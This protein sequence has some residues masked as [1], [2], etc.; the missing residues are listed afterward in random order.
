MTR[1]KYVVASVVVL[2][3]YHRLSDAEFIITSFHIHA[4]P[5]NGGPNSSEKKDRMRRPKGA[6]TS[7]TTNKIY[8]G[9][10]DVGEF[11][12]YCTYSDA[13]LCEDRVQYMM[14]KYKLSEAQA[15]NQTDMLDRCTTPPI[16]R[17]VYAEEDEPYMVLHVGPHKTGTTA[18]QAFIYDLIYAN[19]TIITRDNFRVPSYEELPGVFAKEGVGLNLPHCALEDYKKS[20]GQENIGMCYRMRKEFPKFTVD[21]WNKSQNVLIVAEDFDRKEIDFNRLRFFLRPYNKARIVTTYRRLHDWLPSWY[22]QIMDHYTLKYA[23][24]DEKYPSFVEW[25]GTNFD[26]FLLAHSIE[27]AKRF[28]KYD[29]VESVDILN[30]HDMSDLIE[31][32]FCDHLQ[33]ESTCQAL[34]DGAVPSKSNVGKDHDYERLVIKASL[35]GRLLH[36]AFKPIQIDR[37]T[38]RL[39]EKIEAKN[40]SLPLMCPP[41]D[42]IDK[43]LATEL[44]QERTYFPEW[45]KKQGGEEGVTESFRAAVKKKF[46]SFDDGR[47]FQFGIL[48]DI[49]KEINPNVQWD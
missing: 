12:R 7:N 43:I 49:F 28:D 11:C 4:Q 17:K 18:M 34:K 1:F 30:M 46:C 15:K 20:G 3:A 13:L 39:K 9:S 35:Q 8:T 32:F 29:F 24:G 37:T 48:D 40:M 22:N 25:L 14:K 26:E 23:A 21:A 16:H 19:D 31:H 41:K 27:V 38:R 44:D 45:F 6:N 47:I 5:R 2:S 10:Y 33:A 36:K 42:L